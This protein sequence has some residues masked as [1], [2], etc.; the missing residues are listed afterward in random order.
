MDPN[1]NLTEQLEIAQQIIS[2]V[3]Q[4]VVSGDYDDID[5]EE[6]AVRLAEL[7]LALDEWIRRG[8]FL[9]GAWQA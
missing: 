5:L 3:A 1:A 9:P 2:G 4:Q 6:D 8:G 7:V